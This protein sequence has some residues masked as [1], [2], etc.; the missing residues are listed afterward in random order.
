MSDKDNGHT[1]LILASAS[2]RRVE[3][4]AQVGI[5][6]DHIIP[7]DVDETPLKDESP[8][9]YAKRV[10]ELKARAISKD[11]P[12]SLILAAD[13]VVAV[14]RRI[15]GKADDEPMPGATWN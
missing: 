6:P 13:T 8:L 2:P 12:D 15:L 10:A 3:L 14:G 4:L 9:A 11:H 7:A 1:S 5:V